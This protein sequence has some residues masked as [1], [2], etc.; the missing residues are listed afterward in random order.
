[1][2]TTT[3]KFEVAGRIVDIASPADIRQRWGPGF[4]RQQTVE[5]ARHDDN[6]TKGRSAISGPYISSQNKMR[7]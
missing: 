5:E 7:G 3:S 1:L 6:M 4:R 2:L